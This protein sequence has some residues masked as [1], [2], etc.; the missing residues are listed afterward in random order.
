MCTVTRE[1]IETGDRLKLIQQCGSGLE[2][3]D[4]PAAS[5]APVWTFSGRSRLTRM[6][7]SL[8]TMCWQRPISE[9][10][11]TFRCGGLSRQWL[12]ISAESGTTRSRST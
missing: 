2:G 8:R 10:P 11:R 12:R 1:L 3:V 4:I 6:I 5:Q 9:D 7:P